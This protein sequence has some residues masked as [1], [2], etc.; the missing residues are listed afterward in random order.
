MLSI[1]QYEPDDW[2]RIW[3]FLEPVLREGETFAFPRDMS[4]EAARS[5]W[6]AEPR[7]VFV[8]VD[9]PGGEILGSY[10]LKP[11][12]E[13]PGSHI[14]NCGY[15]VAA[16]ARGNGVATRMCEHSQQE[17]ARR[18]FR[19]MQFNLVV[20]TNETAVR[21]WRNMGFDIIGTIPGG[22]LHPRHGYVDTYIM[23]KALGNSIPDMSP[24]VTNKFDVSS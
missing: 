21:L 18:G 5:A 16:N 12:F 8:A 19:A 6:T 17:A 2:V 22:F 11:N 14:C 24:N 20:S 13:G 7:A 3:S 15:V 10:Y 4:T 23:Y 1:R 9:E